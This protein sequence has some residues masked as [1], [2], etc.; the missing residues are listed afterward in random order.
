[1]FIK[2]LFEKQFAVPVGTFRSPLPPFLRGKPESKSPN[3]SRDLEGAKTFD[4][5]NKT[6]QT[7]SN[8]TPDTLSASKSQKQDF[9]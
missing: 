6:F 5:N 9:A 2:R 3:L 4:T 1:M 7:S 8:T